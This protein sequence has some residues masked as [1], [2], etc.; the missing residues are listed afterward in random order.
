MYNPGARRS[1]VSILHAIQIGPIYGSFC[2]CETSCRSWSFL[3]CLY[4]MLLLLPS[5]FAYCFY[6]P[7]SNSIL[8]LVVFPF[9]SL[10]VW[11]SV[12]LCLWGV[13]LW[14]WA[15]VCECGFGLCVC[16]VVRVCV[17]VGWKRLLQFA[18][19]KQLKKF[20][21][22]RPTFIHERKVS[23]VC[24]YVT[25]TMHCQPF[26]VQVYLIYII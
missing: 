26:H 19:R 23:L 15:F 22:A 11:L 9:L 10:A 18:C 24:V 20:Q 12:W 4:R 21:S 16:V 7:I 3:F 14:E 8:F 13:C 2:V 5:L 17:C 1:Y 6:Y 25:I